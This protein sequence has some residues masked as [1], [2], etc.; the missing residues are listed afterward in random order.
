LNY[1]QKELEIRPSIHAAGTNHSSLSGRRSD[2]I[3]PRKIHSFHRYFKH[4]YC[5]LTRM[6]RGYGI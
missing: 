6:E 2:F 1:T 4:F 5:K 3:L